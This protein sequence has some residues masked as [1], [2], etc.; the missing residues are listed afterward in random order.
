MGQRE[1]AA[2]SEAAD[3]EVG[4]EPYRLEM[5]DYT[6]DNIYGQVGLTAVERKLE[7]LPLFKRL[8]NISQLGLVNWIYPCALHTRYVHSIGV[9]HTAGEMA[10]RINAN[11]GYAF[12]DDSDIQI[13]R[14][15]GMLHDIGHYPMSHNVEQAYKDVY[16]S[17]TRKKQHEETAMEKFGKYTNC[18]EY[19]VPGAKLPWLEEN[20]PK[21][22]QESLVEIKKDVGLKAEESSALRSGGSEYFHHEN[23]GRSLIRADKSIRR[24]VRDY[25]VLMGPKGSAVLNP[26]FAPLGKNGKPR[27][28]ISAREVEKITDILLEA[29]GEMV[30]GNYTYHSETVYPW[31]GRYSAMIQLIHS[32]LDADNLDYLLRDATFSGTSYGTMDMSQLLNCLTVAELQDTSL[33]VK[34]ETRY[35]VGVQAR[36]LGCVEQFLLNKFLAYTQMILSKYVSIL[37]AMLLRAEVDYIIP[38]D[39]NE[40]TWKRLKRMVSLQIK[41]DSEE[42]VIPRDGQDTPVAYVKFSDHYIQQKIYELGNNS[43]VLREP[44]DVIISRLRNLSAFDLCTQDGESECLCTG[45]SDK[46]IFDIVSKSPV[47]TRFQLLCERLEAEWNQDPQKDWDTDRKKK[48]DSAKKELFAFRFEHYALTKQEPL[49]QFL[50]KPTFQSKDETVDP[51]RAFQLNYYRLGDG[52]PILSRKEYT[53]SGSVA[54]DQAAAEL[55]PLSVDCPQSCLHKLWDMQYVSLREY[56]IVEFEDIV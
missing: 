4:K 16:D 17:L 38:Q 52:I 5:L 48:W 34:G 43:N 1:T 33:G 6:L 25:F 30:R 7:R 42:T 47:Y 20:V 56:N 29:I 40:Y 41:N 14:L 12:F 3:Y 18:P 53:Y 15:A 54:L 28:S 55:P 26:K 31:L 37:E 21:D 10:R 36:G 45:F 23:V 24:I 22:G 8:H 51:V 39:N 9:M 19:L 44:L 2:A 11:M 27:K 50:D 32:E 46:E 49:K 13:I 35:I